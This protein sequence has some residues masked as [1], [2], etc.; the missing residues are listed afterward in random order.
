ML[1]RLSLDFNAIFAPVCIPVVGIVVSIFTCR[2]SAKLQKEL[3]DHNEGGLFTRET[4][5]ICAVVP[6]NTVR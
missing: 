1:S 2:Q 5:V 6:F 3:V 4:S